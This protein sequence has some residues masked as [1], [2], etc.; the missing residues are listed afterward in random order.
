M[1]SSRLL[2]LRVFHALLRLMF[3]NDVLT[4]AR[5]AGFYVVGAHIGVPLLF[6]HKIFFQIPPH[7]MIMINTAVSIRK[8]DNTRWTL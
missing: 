3:A 7:R 6:I 2:M 4:F 1:L 8:F 5:V